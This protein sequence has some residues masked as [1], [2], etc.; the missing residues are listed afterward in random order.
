MKHGGFV[1]MLSTQPTKKSAGS[2]SISPLNTTCLLRAR[3]ADHAES[4]RCLYVVGQTFN[5]RSAPSVAAY[6]KRGEPTLDKASRDVLAAADD[7]LTAI[8]TLT[9]ADEVQRGTADHLQLFLD[10]AEMALV[11]ATMAWRE[12]GR[13]N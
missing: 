10:D 2:F 5:H 4:G 8:L 1:P 9:A 3:N 13:P 12:A 6:P 7:W 11:A